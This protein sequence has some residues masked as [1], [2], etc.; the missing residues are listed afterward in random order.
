MLKLYNTL[1]RK[2]EE[3]KP[4]KKGEVGMY[5][6]GPTVYSYP[7]IGNMLRDIFGDVLT[8]VLIYDGYKVKRVMNVTDVGHLTGDSDEGED[9]ME[10]AASKEGKKA[11]DIANFYWSAFKEDFKKL[12]IKNPDIWCKATEHIKEQIELIKK[13]EEKGYTYK[14]SDGIYFDTSKLKDY[15]KLSLLDKENIK[16]GARVDLGDKKN[17][18]DFALWKF[19][20]KPGERQQEWKSPWGLGFPGWHIECSAMSMKYLGE[21]FDLHTGGIDNMFPHHENEIAQSEAAT[22]KKFVNYWLHNN[23]LSIKGEK[24]SKSKGGLYTISELEEL[25]YIP[26][27][28]RYMC[29]LAHYRSSLDFSLELLSAAKNGYEG[30]KNKISLIDEN[31]RGSDGEKY[32]KDFQKAIDDDLNMPL[33]LQSLQLLLKDEKVGGK[34]KLEIIKKMDEVFGL[35]LLKKEKVSV[36]SEVKKLAEERWDAKKKKDFKLADELRAKIS[37]LGFAVSDN[38]DTYEIKRI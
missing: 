31:A 4:I 8:R 5:E 3:F 11:E 20:E 25:G 30:L 22:G 38:L 13:L 36:P 34:A 28:F 19:S 32:L 21:H 26:L 37:D 12:N 1:T 2:K 33:A 7:H 9:K 17:K 6:C 14:T 27:V 16:A 10:K 18:T 23:F 15:G 24:I 35:D 29:L